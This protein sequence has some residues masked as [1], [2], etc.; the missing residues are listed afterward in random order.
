[1]TNG[2]YRGLF[3]RA[4]NDSKQ[5][6][7]GIRISTN[8]S[9]VLEQRPDRKLLLSLKEQNRQI[10]QCIVSAFGD[11]PAPQP[12]IVGLDC[13]ALQKARDFMLPLCEA[14]ASGD[15]ATPDELKSQRDEKFKLVGKEKPTSRG[16]K[17]PA[18]ATVKTEK[19]DASTSAVKEEAVATEEAS[20]GTEVASEKVAKKP[21]TKAK[22]KKE[23]SAANETKTAEEQA[24]KSNPM[25]KKKRSAASKTKAT[26]APE[27]TVAPR[28][29]AVVAAQS[30]GGSSTAG[31]AAPSSGSILGFG[32]PPLTL[33]EQLQFLRDMEVCPPHAVHPPP[34]NPCFI[35]LSQGFTKRY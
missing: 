8:H 18:A 32:P 7:S 1:M 15:I 30:S 16:M 26:T 12:A 24:A 3:K 5:L 13:L 2:M 35:V 11:L 20:E 19:T 9:L 25:D 21:A 27:P 6:W 34:S 28:A 10:L 22:V 33:Y 31:S 29:V 17:R 23:Q 14:S 4:H